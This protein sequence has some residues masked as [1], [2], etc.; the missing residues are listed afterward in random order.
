V[1]VAGPS[2]KHGKQIKTVVDNVKS[3]NIATSASGCVLFRAADALRVSFSK[4]KMGTRNRVNPTIPAIG[5]GFVSND[6]RETHCPRRDIHLAARSVVSFITAGMSRA[7]FACGVL[8][9]TITL[10]AAI[11]TATAA[12][13]RV[14]LLHSFGPHFAPWN[15]IA[16]RLREELIKQSPDPV[17]LYE[18][19]LQFGRRAPPQDQAP[20]VGYIGALF[21]ESPP[22]LLVA[23]GAPAAQFFLKHRSEIFPTTPLLISGAD[24]RT[25]AD[26]ELGV[27]GTA[28]AVNI[29]VA[30]QVDAMLRVLPDITNIAVIIG[31]SP[32]ERFWIAEMQR[33][34]KVFADRVTFHWLN[35]LPFEEM[36]KSVSALPAHSAIFYASVRVDAA[37]IPHE[38]SRAITR[39]RQAANAAIFGYADNDFGRGIVGGPHISI[40]DVANRSAAVAARIFAGEP[41]GSI[42]PV[43]VGLGQPM[44][45]WRE[46]RHWNISEG[47]LPPESRVYFREASAWERYRWEMQAIGA[48]LLL[49][50]GLIA[51]L[52]HEHRRRHEA[53]VL[54]RSSISE[55][56]QMNRVAT[57]GELSAS[58][59]HEVGQPLTGISALAT[60]ALQ[61]LARDKP[62]IEKTR[63]ALTD[64]VAASHSASELVTSVR[65]MFTK[66]PNKPQPLDINAVIGAVLGILRVELLSHR[67]EVQT[68]LD[69]ALPR[70]QCD[71]VQLQQVIV[72]LVMNAMEAMHAAAP[73]VLR[74]KTSLAR[75]GVVN[76]SIEDTG[77]GIDPA[78]RDRLFK[79]LVTTKANGMGMGLAICQSIIASHK[80][81]IWASAAAGKGSVFQFELPTAD[82]R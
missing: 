10:L 35:E 69:P 28:V 46:L 48:A 1:K 26:T 80:G 33:S 32:L 54:A 65:A 75:P 24:T 47:R 37:G 36:L 38:E 44:Y 3:G 59:A 17:D 42:K 22:D 61:W 31:D 16:A 21:H 29:D 25:F 60:A 34:F 56:Q 64:I 45:D 14:L 72:N 23:I 51:W 76:V 68:Q 2:S 43:T 8:L 58:I 7:R 11:Q 5:A 49:Q 50:A 79:P 55:L 13:R 30:A 41:A 82:A 4:L 27:N 20:F 9:A 39:L 73:R 6:I 63:A 40:D 19:S 77:S 71:R 57:A 74:I 52:I 66:K 62:D 53:E 18:A 15:Q 12:P 70:V 78:N 67:I 81:R